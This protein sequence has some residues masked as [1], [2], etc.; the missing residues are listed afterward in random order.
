MCGM[1]RLDI[2]YHATEMPQGRAYSEEMMGG[3]LEEFPEKFANVSPGRF[4]D[5]VRGHVMIVH[6][7]TD[8]NVG[9]ENTHAAIRELTAAGIPHEVLLFPDEGH[10]VFRRGNVETFLRASAAFLEQAFAARMRGG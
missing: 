6:G 10:G 5:R 2:D 4:I 8:S 1:Y 7:R 3:T 9:P